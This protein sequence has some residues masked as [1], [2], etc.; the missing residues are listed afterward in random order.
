MS[1]KDNNQQIQ[2]GDSSELAPR[3][4][5]K[6]KSVRNRGV[7]QTMP[8]LVIPR[9]KLRGGFI[10]L[11]EWVRDVRPD[12]AAVPTSTAPIASPPVNIQCTLGGRVLFRRGNPRGRLGR[13]HEHRPEGTCLDE[14]GQQ[15]YD[16]EQ[17]IGLVWGVRRGD[18]LKI[19]Q[20]GAT[21][22][23]TPDF[24]LLQGDR[25]IL[26]I[27]LSWF[28]PGSTAACTAELEP[29]TRAHASVRQRL[30]A[31]PT[32]PART[33]CQ[34]PGRA[35]GLS[36]SRAESWWGPQRRHCATESVVLLGWCDHP[37]LYSTHCKKGQRCENSAWLRD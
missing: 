14:Q 12:L 3:L 6:G 22:L 11:Y 28:R 15:R 31:C 27:P 34:A 18:L 23:G 24:S 7:S 19:K 13:W 29:G 2:S 17:D 20:P 9:S 16:P 33:L 37:A 5:C 8:F 32:A 21:P 10:S 30:A 36:A 1:Y 26:I 4:P 25:T 35:P